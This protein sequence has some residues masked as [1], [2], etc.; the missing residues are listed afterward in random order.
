MMA[1]SRFRSAR[2]SAS[3]RFLKPLALVRFFLLRV[4]M[5]SSSKNRQL[6]TYIFEPELNVFAC[7]D[8]IELLVVQVE[9]E[10]HRAKVT[11]PQ[12]FNYHVLIE[13]HFATAIK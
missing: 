8:R 1:T 7:L 9:A 11:L 5:T 10:P 13:H 4:C 12:G 6:Q 2:G 3:L